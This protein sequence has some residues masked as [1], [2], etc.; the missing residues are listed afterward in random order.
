MTKY[1]C[2]RCGKVFNTLVE[3]MIHIINEHG[4]G[5]IFTEEVDSDGQ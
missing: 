2:G 3:A 4:F 1:K 5:S